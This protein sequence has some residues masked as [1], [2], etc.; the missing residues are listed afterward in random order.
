M[1]SFPYEKYLG[2]KHTYN[3]VLTFKLVLSL[4]LNKRILA[5]HAE[6]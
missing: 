2:C 5:M 3:M 6:F 1:Y 4:D